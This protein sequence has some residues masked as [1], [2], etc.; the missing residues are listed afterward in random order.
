MGAEE[1][2]KSDSHGE[3]T[4]TGSQSKKQSRWTDG[5]GAPG[6]EKHLRLPPFSRHSC[7][8]SESAL[9]AAVSI[10]RMIKMAS[11]LNLGPKELVTHRTGCL[12][13][14]TGQSFHRRLK[15]NLLHVVGGRWFSVVTPW[16]ERPKENITACCYPSSRSTLKFTETVQVSDT[17]PGWSSW[18]KASIW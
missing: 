12:G 17:P 5:R 18:K 9:F 13:Q 15:T 11:A 16:R 8:N 1:R 10:K 4:G 3:K 14:R 6:K 7:W 2:Q